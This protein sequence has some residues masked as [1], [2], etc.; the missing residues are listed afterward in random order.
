M[1]INQILDLILTGTSVALVVIVAVYTKHKI[2]IDRKAQQGNQIAKAEQIV[3]QVVSPLVY[4]AE[5]D[6]GE[7]TAKFTQVL[8]GI[9]DILD[10]A[11][12]P[13]PTS[14]YLSGEIEKSVAT[15][16]KTQGLI[17]TVNNSNKGEKG[18]K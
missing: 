13:H 6:G 18:D 9:L 11:H 3:A 1:T 16:K 14:A 8:N 5:K 17:D 12:L 4:Q 15:M 7:G 10:L 2:E